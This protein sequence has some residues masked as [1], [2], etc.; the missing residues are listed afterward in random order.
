MELP[1]VGEISFSILLRFS[2]PVIIS[3]YFYLF[4]IRDPIQAHWWIILKSSLSKVWGNLANLAELES[5]SALIGSI[6]FLIFISSLFLGSI[7][8][9]IYRNLCYELIIYQFQDWV[10]WRLKRENYRTY[11]QKS[12]RNYK[13]PYE[14]N[15]K[16]SMLLWSQI[17]QKFLG[18]YYNEMLG[19][20][21][22]NI[23]MLYLAGF[24][25]IP[26]TLFAFFSGYK[27]TTILFLIIFFLFSGIGFWADWNYEDME[28]AALCSID[29][30]QELFDFME[31]IVKCECWGKKKHKN[32]NRGAK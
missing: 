14:I 11:L 4:N 16:Q 10:R 8:F 26:F 1:K 17:R 2:S 31:E 22:S 28:L 25:A 27:V 21:A 23:H 19:I 5:S 12:L 30:K 18:G 15:S 20:Y 6:I 29:N 13:T 3:F 7:I 24:I 9:T 32:A